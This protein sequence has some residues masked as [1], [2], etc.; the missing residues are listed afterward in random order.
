D[1]TLWGGVIGE[2]GLGGIKLAP[3]GEGR[4]YYDFQKLLF[5]LSSRGAILAINSRNNEADARE[6]IDKHPHMLLRSDAFVASRIN[7][8]DKATNLREIAT[9]LN[10]G[11][12]SLV[13]LDDDP[14][15]RLLVKNVLPEVSVI[16]LPNDHTMYP[17]VLMDYRG[18]NSFEF[19][20][21]DQKR[22]DMYRQDAARKELKRSHLDL[23][24]FLADLKIEISIDQV[25]STM[26]PR[27]AQLTQKTNQFNLTTKRYQ[28]EDV[29]RLVSSGYR[30]WALRMRD[31]FGDYG[32]T[33]VC[34]VFSQSDFW[35]IDSLLLSC[36]I[37]G[38][39]VEE[40]F[41]G[42]ILNLLKAIEPKKILGC[43]IPTSKNHQVK[44]FYQLFG[45]RKTKT[46]SG[47]DFWERDLVDY[48][49]KPNN[50][51][52]TRLDKK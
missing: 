46:E 33:G 7:W 8:Q 49:F 9:E 6:V 11:L 26:I 22:S 2:D 17:R 39:R 3:N 4:P 48:D 45:F 16:E 23:D 10:L 52:M 30:L 47:A 34:I 35:I 37:L 50:F 27:V 29:N 42:H 14:S 1:N 12:D 44:D 24:S 43:Y 21:E 20:E 31:R 28:E 36:R 38:K 32:L 15:N 25:S 40:Q 51:I 19:T 41:L 18:F 13:F 5:N